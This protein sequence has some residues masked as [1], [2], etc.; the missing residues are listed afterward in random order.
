[1]DNK[2][3]A[4]AYDKI[5]QELRRGVLILAVLSQLQEE[6]HGYALISTLADN[7]LMID[8][9]TL[10]PLLRRL[11][12]QG[13]LQSQWNTEGARPRRYY[14]ITPAGVAVLQTLQQDWAELTAV[15]QRLLTKQEETTNGID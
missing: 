14:V 10:Y 1:M 12:A 15:M 7:G 5:S 6:T 8:Q 2:S 4:D 13:L 9:G 11:E 3:Q